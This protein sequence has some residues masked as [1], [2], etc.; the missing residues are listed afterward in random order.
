MRTAKSPFIIAMAVAISLGLMY[1]QLCGVLCDISGCSS[2]V[3]ASFAAVQSG[4]DVDAGETG[5]GHHK[6]TKLKD[7]KESGHRSEGLALNTSENSGHRHQSGCLHGHDQ[8]G[9]ISTGS[10]S[11]SNFNQ[12]PLPTAEVVSPSAEILFLELSG[13]TTARIP[14]R[15]PPRRVASVLRI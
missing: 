12:Q 8:I 9:L 2:S 11:A 15:S 3:T 7:S 14:D 13:E 4:G 10:N 1:S 6:Q 5:C